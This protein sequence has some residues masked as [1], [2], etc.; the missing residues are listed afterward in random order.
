[1]VV[2]DNTITMNELRKRSE[3]LLIC[4]DEAVAM[5]NNGQQISGNL[6]VTH[7]AAGCVSLLNF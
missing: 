1:M 4:I 3:S 7:I 5:D 6:K 2:V